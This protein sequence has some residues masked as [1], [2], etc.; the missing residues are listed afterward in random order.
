MQSP[1]TL[2]TLYKMKEKGEKIVALTAY[3]NTIAKIVD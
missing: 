3:A 2:T 1:V